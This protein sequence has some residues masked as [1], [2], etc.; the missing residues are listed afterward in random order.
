MIKDRNLIKKQIISGVLIGLLI[1]ALI[2]VISLAAPPTSP[3]QP[4][5]TLDPN[6]SP[7]DPNCT[8]LPAITSLNGLTTT[9]QTF[10]VGTAGN[11]FNIVSTGSIHIFNLPDASTF[12]R[13][14]VSTGTQTFAGDKTFIGNLSIS[15]NNNLF[16]V[17]KGK[18]ESPQG[19]PYDWYRGF[20]YLGKDLT[21]DEWQTSTMDPVYN[22]AYLVLGVDTDIGAFMPAIYNPNDLSY[23]RAANIEG[24]SGVFQG[25]IYLQK[26]EGSSIFFKPGGSSIESEIKYDNLNKKLFLI[27]YNGNFS[28]QIKTE[29]PIVN[30]IFSIYN[31]ST[32]LLSLSPSGDLTVNGFIIATSGIACNDPDAGCGWYF[33]NKDIT[34]WYLKYD[35]YGGPSLNLSLGNIN[36]PNYSFKIGFDNG[37]NFVPGIIFSNSGDIKLNS[38][39]S[40]IYGENLKIWG[41]SNSNLLLQP[42]D[43]SSGNV[44]IGTTAP[45]EKLDVVGNI[46][47]S[48]SL[49]LS[50]LTPGSVLFAGTG[51]LISQDNAN[52][53]WDNINKRLGIGTTNPAG[54]LH[55]T[56][57][58]TNALVID[59]SGNV[60]IGTT[61]PFSLLE[62]YKNNAHSILTITSATSTTYSPQIQFRTGNPP[63]VNY[64]MGVERTYN[65]FVITNSNDVNNFNNGISITPYNVGIGTN[66]PSTKLHV[67][68]NDRA[69]L[70][71]EGYNGSAF[72]YSINS[73]TNTGKWSLFVDPLSGF[74]N[75]GAFMIASADDTFS[76]FNP[77]FVISHSSGNI[78][79]GTTTPAYKLHVIGSIAQT[80]A[81]NCS[82]SADANG[83]I[84]C[85][86]SSL[87]YKENIQDLVFDKEKFL[88]LQPRTFE[89]KKDLPFKIEGKQVGFVAEEVA[90]TFPE[91]VRYNQNNEPEGI[92]YENI[93]V[94]LYSIVKDLIKNFVSYVKDALTQLGIIIENGIVKIEKM[95]VKEVVI[96]FAEIKEA[97][98][99]K[100]TINQ[101]CLEDESGTV[102][103]NKQDLKNILE[104][105]GIIYNQGGGG[106]STSQN[107]LT[108]S[109]NT[110]EGQASSG[111]QENNF[112]TNSI[113]QSS[114]SNINSNQ[115]DSDSQ[116]QNSS[117]SQSDSSN[118]S[119]NSTNNQSDSLQNQPSDNQNSSASQESNQEQSSQN[120]ANQQPSNEI[121][122]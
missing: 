38:P 64:S 122:Q 53:Y 98:I 55:V 12:S 77:R 5:E 20:V 21:P 72:R 14:L 91:L 102:C 78:G 73:L 62:L 88:S 31:S 16:F 52:L 58:T 6:C 112:S 100:A 40:N 87:K 101:L 83:Q 34:D 84:I 35:G 89:F 107:N 70:F 15:G 116:I 10:L 2:L 36:N 106:Q 81:L 59:N 80:N 29:I 66:I 43:S 7:G 47:A 109:S 99:N 82:L 68:S 69:I 57:G 33:R 27:G 97:K 8:V 30:E 26:T 50:S 23:L 115:Q 48:G 76:S 61:T 25:D 51:G 111:N 19:G 96:D 54:I 44:G 108:T 105:N 119:Q 65:S 114:S 67:Y 17:N 120:S 75:T 42:P 103:I 90:T 93:S 18:R 45:S 94:Y 117:N 1:N 39:W 4:G 56:T 74:G 41:N 92:K 85:T 28:F 11:D 95:F 46:K 9:T 13:G 118:Q 49:T 86:V 3:Y 79:I 110:N 37:T 113:D 63:T 121:Q 22:S 60:G 71:L 32:P 104:R 24:A